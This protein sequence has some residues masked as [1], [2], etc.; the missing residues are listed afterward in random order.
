MPGGIFKGD[1]FLK[2]VFFAELSENGYREQ[3]EAAHSLLK[4]ELAPFLGCNASKIIIAKDDNGRPFV[5]GRA[6]VFISISHTKGAV[7]VGFSDRPL[8]VDIEQVKIRRKSVENRIFTKSESTL[9]DLSDNENKAFFTLW[10]LKESYLK[11][12]GTGFADNA[13]S[14]EFLN[15]ANPVK[16]NCEA[17]AFETGEYNGCVFSVCEKN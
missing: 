17:F 11:A 2:K 12:I 4:K 14:I 13:K 3:S 5:L 10:T 1:A 6:D 16:S 8:G 15:V 7:M 9:V